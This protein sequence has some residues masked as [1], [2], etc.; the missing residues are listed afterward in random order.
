M[1]L[2]LAFLV[3]MDPGGTSSLSRVCCLLGT[4]AFP[5]M[6]LFSLLPGLPAYLCHLDSSYEPLG[7]PALLQ[8]PFPSVSSLSICVYFRLWVWGRLSCPNQNFQFML[9][10][11]PYFEAKLG[12]GLLWKPW[13]RLHLR[14]WFFNKYTETHGPRQ[15]FF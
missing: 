2:N 7:M 9:D 13:G 3:T 5:P 1:G 15:A 14:L 11:E 12:W 6:S 4:A 8:V 10:K